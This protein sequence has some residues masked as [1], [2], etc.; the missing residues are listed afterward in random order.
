LGL[1]IFVASLSLALLLVGNLNINLIFVRQIS[2]SPLSLKEILSSLMIIRI[3]AGVFFLILMLALSLLLGYSK[4]KFHFLLIALFFLF[5]DI[6]VSFNY[7][8]IAVKKVFYCVMLPIMTKTG[9]IIL[10]IVLLKKVNPAIESVILAQLIRSFIIITAALLVTHLK[11]SKLSFKIHKER[12]IELLRQTPP[13]ILMALAFLSYGYIA[14]FWLGQLEG[15]SS[16][17]PFGIAFSVVNIFIIIPKV[18]ISVI[19][20]EASKSAPLFDRRDIMRFSMLVLAF[21]LILVI[22]TSQSAIAFD[23]VLGSS[24]QEVFVILQQLIW[25]LPGIFLS[26]FFVAMLQAKDQEKLT[27][28][29]GLICLFIYALALP[30]SFIIFEMQG[31]ILTMISVYSLQ[32]IILGFFTFKGKNADI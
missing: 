19:F 3:F 1:Y 11:I 10:L 13:F 26:T 28:R 12:V 22:I 29:V 23:L 32:S 31:L 30:M 15:L 16:V 18:I 8:F 6:F 21:S 5:D 24:S 2:R 9:F 27:V 4:F 20:P 7:L 14:I 17:T 25:I